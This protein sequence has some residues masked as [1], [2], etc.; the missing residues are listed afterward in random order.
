MLGGEMIEKMATMMASN[1]SMVGGAVSKINSKNMQF[2]PELNWKFWGYLFVL[3]LIFLLIRAY[4]VQVSYNYIMPR[5]TTDNNVKQQLSYE[6]SIVLLI[7]TL[8]LFGR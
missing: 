6:E 2:E 5:L 4:L 1:G 3:S 8:T 7:L